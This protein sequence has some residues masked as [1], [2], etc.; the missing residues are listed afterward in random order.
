M[1]QNQNR[2]ASGRKRGAPTLAEAA[3]REA[4]KAPATAEMP[5][6]DPT[7]PALIG[8]VCHG[9]GRAQH[10]RVYKTD[11]L[12]RYVSCPLCGCRM[13]MRYEG[14]RVAEIQRI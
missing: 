12:L 5:N 4:P 11:G 13:K 8:F 9:C 7:L 10:P 1:D 3:A 14:Q 2:Q 6:P